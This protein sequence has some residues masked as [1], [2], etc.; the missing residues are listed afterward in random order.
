[1]HCPSGKKDDEMN[2][3]PNRPDAALKKQ[4]E[5]A[6]IDTTGMSKKDIDKKAAMLRLGNPKKYTA[7]GEDLEEAKGE[8][9]D[10]DPLDG[11]RAEFDKDHDGVPDGADKDPD[12]PEIKEEMEIQIGTPGGETGTMDDLDEMHCPSGKKDDEMNEGH[13]DLHTKIENMLDDGK[14]VDEIVA[15][16]DVSKD[17]VDGVKQDM[18][19]AKNEQLKES[20]RKR[21]ARLI[22]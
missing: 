21:F 5:D 17:D 1:M 18:K 3:D 15:A 10:A 22:R 13:K 8:K 14:S 2:E 9:G 20:M 19:A 6:G 16:L 11:K 7:L 12:D 4:L